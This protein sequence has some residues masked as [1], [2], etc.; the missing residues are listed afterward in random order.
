MLFRDSLNRE[1]RQLHRG[2]FTTDNDDAALGNMVTFFVFFMIVA[3]HRA[4]GDTCVFLQNTPV[5]P[6]VTADVAVIEQDAG[7]D[8]GSGMHIDVSA[9][10]GIPYLSP[11]D[12]TA[13]G[14][15]RIDGLSPAI[16]LVE[17]ELGRRIGIARGTQRPLTVE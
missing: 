6:G 1:R 11:G 16:F 2:T 14:N 5:Q 3:D 12:D 10:N 7:I 15:D 17:R 13:P 9:Q 4:L 8:L